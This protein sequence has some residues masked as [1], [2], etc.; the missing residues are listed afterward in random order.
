M[1]PSA[2][3]G[4]RPNRFWTPLRTSL[5]VIV[6]A[7]LAALG[8]SSCNSA[9][10]ESGPKANMASNTGI[11]PPKVNVPATILPASALDTALKTIDGKPFKLAELKGKIL[12]ISL[13]A[14]WCG[15]CRSETPELVRIQT[16]YGPRGLE[17][18]ALDIDPESD[19]PEDVKAFMKEFKI[20]YKVAFAERELAVS[21]MRGGNIPQSLVVGRDGRV[22]VHFT[23]FDRNSTPT[24]MR[25]AIEQALQQ[26]ETP[27]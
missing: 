11:T 27:K 16:E 13:W 24:K 8:I 2:Q 5:T 14:T 26:G 17:V 1:N 3:R 18:V 25:T 21:L 20:N 9:T 23:G 15:P 7:L 19:S 10:N 4:K 6:F 12:V 22:I